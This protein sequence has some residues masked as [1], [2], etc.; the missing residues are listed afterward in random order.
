[1]R[2]FRISSGL[3]DMVNVGGALISRVDIF[4]FFCDVAGHGDIYI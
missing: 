1:M 4:E 3:R 2:M